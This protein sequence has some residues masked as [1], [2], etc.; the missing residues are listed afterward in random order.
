MRSMAQDSREPL[1]HRK[2][3]LIRPEPENPPAEQAGLQVFFEVNIEPGGP[4][5]APLHP[6]APFD[7]DEAAAG[8]VGEIGPTASPQ[9]LPRA[10]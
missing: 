8:Q 1:Y 2:R 5:V 4:V 9:T 7:L 6:D 3:D 10:A